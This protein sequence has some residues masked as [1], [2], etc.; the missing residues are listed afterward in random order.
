VFLLSVLGT[1]LFTFGTA[2]A[3]TE[4]QFVVLQMLTRTFFVTGSAVG[5]VIV[6]EE[7][8]ASRRGFGIGLLGALSV[9]GW[10]F[11]AALFAFVGHLPFGWRS[12]YVI[13][14]TPILLF[15]RLSRRVTET[16]RFEAYS[17]SGETETALAST[18]LAPLVVLGARRPFRALGIALGGLLPAFGFIGTFQFAGYF[19]QTVH[20]WSPQ[21]YAT[22][23]VVA[24]GVGVLGNLASGRLA[25]RFGRRIVGAM[26]LASFPMFAM[27]FYRGTGAAL[28]VAWAACVFSSQ[29]GRAILRTQATELFPTA[30]RGAA[31]GLF[32]ILEVVGGAAGLFVLGNFIHGPG[33]LARTIPWIAS[34]AALGSVVIGLFP[35]T[36]NRELEST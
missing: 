18:W 6:A 26:E 36:T 24:G 23:V 20:G 7:F 10:G 2:F 29:G 12:L 27:L 33:E 32:A 31:S 25:D 30:S 22:L 5:V 19:T 28:P 16:R 35:E 8:P 1:G 17:R 11:S 15:S 14:L 3:Q 9:S 34:A 21:R 4:A 13:G